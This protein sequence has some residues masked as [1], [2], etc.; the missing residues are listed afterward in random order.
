MFAP[1]TIIALTL[2]AASAPGFSAP[3]PAARELPTN[4]IEA[5][6]I[7]SILE[8]LIGPG[9][10]GI[11][12]DFL[13][14]GSSG[15]A[16][17]SAATTTPVSARQLASIAEG[18][19]GSVG[20]GIESILSKLF[21]R[22]SF[23]DLSDGEVNQLLEYVNGMDKRELDARFSLPSGL[24]TGALKSLGEGALSSAALAGLEKLLGGGS[25]STTTAATPAATDASAAS[26]RADG[27]EAR[28]LASI[29]EGL[30]GPGIEGIIG[31]ILGGG[32]SG[33]ASTGTAATTVST[34]QLASI[35]E[36]VVGSVG[37]GIESILSKLFDRRSFSDLSDGEVNQLLEYVNG[38]DKRELDARFSLPSGLITGALKSLGEGAL[39]SAALAG[40]EKLLGGGSSSATT[41]AAPAATDAP[42]ASRRADGIEARG[43]ASILEGLIG[44]GIEGII[45]DFLGGGSSGTAS[46]GTT[47][48]TVS[49]RQ[50]A[51]IAEG[52][53]GSVG[54]GIESILS[55][56]FDRRSFSD[57][58]DGEVNQ[59]LEYVNGMDKRELDARFSLPSGL[60][61]GALKSLGEGALSSAALAG[62]EKLLGGGSSSTTTAAAPAATD[63]S[64]AS[65]RAFSDLSDDEVNQ[66]LEYVNG[67]GTKAAR[68]LSLNELD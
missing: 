17:S 43:I 4:G 33:T 34:R 31:S 60:I 65:R 16:S 46:S 62:L 67:M 20:S 10:E 15:T 21:D 63:A 58:S 55:K 61:T 42:A 56:L 44:P 26:R 51:S 37:S 29:I 12:G 59:L 66:L 52:V 1:S 2:I 40:L 50:L 54:S 68:S 23:S 47:A 48:T 9:I 13:G 18:V 32:S 7:A 53:V 24:I 28:G 22:R 25:S 39:S 6:G 30:V 3:V 5:R 11:I 8:G 27:I 35:A 19:V 57:L 64:A 14:G 41:T 45:G 36:G 49:T 38:M